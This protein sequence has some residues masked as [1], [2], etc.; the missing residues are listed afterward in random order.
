M[1]DQGSFCLAGASGIFLRA[2]LYAFSSFFF[3]CCSA[4]ICSSLFCPG[5]PPPP[6][7]RPICA[8]A[9]T[10]NIAIIAAIA[11]ALIAATNNRKRLEQT[12][13]LR[14]TQR[15]ERAWPAFGTLTCRR[16]LLPLSSPFTAR[17]KHAADSGN[18]SFCG[19]RRRPCI[20]ASRRSGDRRNLP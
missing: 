7:L 19:A 20:Q 9:G 6:L 3:F 15:Y 4:A 1:L 5:L 2:S 13:N 10:V 14:R 18:R 17:K 11:K 12:L 8:W 16:C